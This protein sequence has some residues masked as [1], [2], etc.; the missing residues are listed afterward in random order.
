M[1]AMLLAPDVTRD[2]QVGDRV[3][4]R[5]KYPCPA[6]RGEAVWRDGPA[7]QVLIPTE[8]HEPHEARLTGTV[9]RRCQGGGHCRAVEDHPYLVGYEERLPV[10]GGYRVNGHYGADELILIE[11]D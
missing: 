2:L 9:I 7:T 1:Q 6:C 4:I 10:V 3:R 11:D 8:G 5:P